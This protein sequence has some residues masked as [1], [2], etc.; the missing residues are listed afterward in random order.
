MFFVDAMEG[1]MAYCNECGA[2]IPD[3]QT[4]CLACGHDETEVKAQNSAA[5]AAASANSGRYGF[6]NDELRR[7]M[8]EQRKKQQEQSR[9]WAEQERERRE[10]QQQ[11][12][13]REREERRARSSS[14]IDFDNVR[15]E[16]SKD[17]NSKEASKLFATLSYL[18]V[19]S[20]I[21]LLFRRDDDYATYHARQGLTLLIYGVVAN[22]LSVIPV[23]GWLFGA[24]RIVCVFKGMIN[25]ANGIKAPLPYIG[26]F[27]ERFR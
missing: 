12:A 9:V 7:R 17:A 24:F 27:A 18:S 4:K 1:K 10:R 23:V 16:A 19:L 3:G 15:S 6:N 13:E 26:K 2:Y 11:R 8:E 20:L 14:G 21:P 25:A 22:V 5:Q